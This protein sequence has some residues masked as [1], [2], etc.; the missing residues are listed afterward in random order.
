MSLLDSITVKTEYT[1]SINLE[2]D[3]AGRGVPHAYVPTARAVQT[4]NR[5]VDTLHD[6]PAPRA[7]ALIGPYGAG[8]SAFGLFLAD[9]LD[10]A[11]SAAAKHAHETLKAVSPEVASRL[12]KL[13]A[14]S[15]GHCVAALTGSPEPMGR[16]LVQALSAAAFQ[17]LSQSQG[18]FQAP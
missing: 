14:G 6:G 16:R 2:R 12:V 13:L 17:A 3:C 5:I 9:L 1:R 15:S 11:D 8:K 10:P 7:W 18:S 4:L